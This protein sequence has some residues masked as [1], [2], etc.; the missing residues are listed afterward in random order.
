MSE[1]PPAEGQSFT[2]RL[3]M[4]SARHRKPV[5]IVW[6]LIVIA[7][8][9]ACFAVPANTDIELKAPGEAGEAFDLFQERFG[10]EEATPRSSWSSPTPPSRSTIRR[11]GR[12]LKG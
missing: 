1:N 12:P 5:A 4:W 7:A 9:A 8:L 3:A 11:I 10:E 2:V 6:V